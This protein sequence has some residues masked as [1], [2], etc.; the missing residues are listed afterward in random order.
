MTKTLVEYVHMLKYECDYCR[1]ELSAFSC[2]GGQRYDFEVGPNGMKANVDFES[3]ERGVL[4][5]E[6][7]AAKALRRLAGAIEPKLKKAGL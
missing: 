2:E 4:F 1:K 5:C 7:C 6:G 3:F